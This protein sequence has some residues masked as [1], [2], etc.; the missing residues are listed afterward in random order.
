MREVLENAGYVV[1]AR[2]NLGSAVDTLKDTQIDLLITRP[3][4]DNITGHEAAKYLRTKSPAMAVLIVAGMLDDDRLTYRAELEHFAIFPP[5]FS[6]AQLLAKIRDIFKTK[7][8]SHST[9]RAI[10]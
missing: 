8:H 1:A 3:H 10:V 5:P 6:A 4:I 7:D 2:D 9:H